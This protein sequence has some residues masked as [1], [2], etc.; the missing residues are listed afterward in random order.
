ML[1]SNT[2]SQ[3]NIYCFNYAL[4]HVKSLLKS[5]KNI[6]QKDAIIVSMDN[7]ETKCDVVAYSVDDI[8]SANG[9]SEFE[10][11]KMDIEGSEAFVFL[12]CDGWLKNV[13]VLIIELHDWISQDCSKNVF[14][15]L[16]NWGFYILIR[17]ENLICFRDY[18]DYMG[19]LNK[20]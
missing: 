8:L 19:S 13:R 6:H 4:W 16:L 7:D 15:A 11:V 18:K 14:K 9:I 17:H 10:V 3:P 20:N 12:N 2:K 5:S 1:I